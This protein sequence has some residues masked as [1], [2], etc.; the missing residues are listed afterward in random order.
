MGNDRQ[1]NVQWKEITIP[2]LL[3]L[4]LLL[5]LF[6]SNP[7][8]SVT[9]LRLSKLLDLVESTNFLLTTVRNIS[10]P[11]SPSSGGTTLQIVT[12]HDTRLASK[13]LQVGMMEISA[14]ALQAVKDV[15]PELERKDWK[16][17]TNKLT[18]HTLRLE[19]RLEG[20]VKNSGLAAKS[21]AEFRT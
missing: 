2:A 3:L 4:L 21:A 9:R 10:S 8:A 15:R 1:K 20:L 6:P 7:S 17:M 19:G 13:T 16:Y 18:S 14:G 12:K 5:T 11:S